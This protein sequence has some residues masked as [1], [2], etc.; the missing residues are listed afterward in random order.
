M[1]MSVR[2][3]DYYTT[4]VA[5]QPGE[6]YRLLS[7]LAGAGVNLLAFT[8]IPVGPARTQLTIFP[9]DDGALVHAA[10]AAS[11]AIDGPHPAFLVQG[12]DTLGALAGIHEKLFDAGVNVYAASGVT[13]GAGSFGYLVYVRPDDFAEAARALGV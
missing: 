11:I 10:K 6:A 5:D 13:D 9:E 3:A 8:A 2:R 7:H 1:T 4:T 12:D